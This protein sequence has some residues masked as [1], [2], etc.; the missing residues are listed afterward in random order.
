MKYLLLFTFFICSLVQAEVP[1]R[2]QLKSTHQFQS[3][4]YYAAK[5]LGYYKDAGLEVELLEASPETDPA[6]VV[7]RGDAEFGVGSNSLVLHRH[8]GKPVVV[9]AVIMQHSPYI[10]LMQRSDDLQNI[11]DLAHK[12]VMI[13]PLADELIAYLN[14][15]QVPLDSIQLIRDRHNIQDFI[16]GK[17]EAISACD[18]DETYLLNQLNIDYYALT[19]RSA[20]I[21]FYGDNLFTTEQQINEHPDRVRNF[22]AASLRGWT[23]AMQHPQQVIDL[24][25]KKY[26]SNKEREYLLY[27]SRKMDRLMQPELISVG[28][29]FE[30]RWRHIAQTYAGLGMMSEGFSLDGFIYQTEPHTDYFWM[31]FWAGVSLIIVI[32]ALVIYNTFSNLNK[33]L[34]RLLHIKSQFTNIGDSVNNITHQWKQPLNE[35]SLQFMLIERSAYNSQLSRKEKKE[36]TLRTTKC[37]DILEHM[38]STLDLFST[39]LRPDKSRTSFKPC[40]SINYLLQLIQENFKIRNI[41]ITTQLDKDITLPGNKYEMTQV[42]LSILNNARDIFEQRK[43]E[44]PLIHIHLY[45]IKNSIHIDISDNGGGIKVKPLDRIFKP[46]YSN[47]NTRD[48]GVGLYIARNIIEENFQGQLSA[49]TTEDGATFHISIPVSGKIP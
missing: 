33:K 34:L 12:K 32:I 19:S 36:I 18:T 29:M 14:K 22:R 30:G 46:G 11:Q 31:F 20:G 45:Q 35:L 40:I 4:G 9:L 38:A 5:E 24:I 37:H 27:E 48:S 47:K 13:E 23:Y 15:E 41:K 44:S 21:D 39:L 25:L 7:L 26:P 2:L 1:V 3:A 16:D 8:Q 43:T 49:T 6:E 42:L 17:I 10:L 28:Y